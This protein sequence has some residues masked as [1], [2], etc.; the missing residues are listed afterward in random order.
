M[1]E[2]NHDWD[3]EAAFKRVADRRGMTVEELH[4]ELYRRANNP[5]EQD[6]RELEETERM[7]HSS[8]GWYTNT[9]S[10]KLKSKLTLS[11]KDV[12]FMGVCGGLGEYANL[13]P[14]IFRVGFALG[15]LLLSG[16]PILLYLVLVF[17]MPNAE[18]LEN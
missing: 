8:P 3:P 17:A 11:S 14:T 15:T 18:D 2:E 5:T 7:L 10:T 6:I 13:D 16:L 12:K 1:N 4:A 9:N